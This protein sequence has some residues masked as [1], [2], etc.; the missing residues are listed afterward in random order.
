MNKNLDKLIPKLN[1]AVKFFQ[2]PKIYSQ[3]RIVSL[4]D[5]ITTISG[6]DGAMY[7]ELIQF[8]HGIKGIVL[9]LKE[10]E[11]GAV[12]FGNF[13]KLK[14]G[15]E[16]ITTGKTLAIPVNENLLG[17]VIN[18]LVQPL[19]SSLE[20]SSGKMMPLEKI[21]PGVITRQ[22]VNTP[23]HTGIKAIDSMIPIGRGQRELII[24]DKGTGKTAIAID[25]IINQKEE[26]V[27]CVYVAIGQ[28][29][30][31]IARIREELKRKGAMKYTIIVA[32]N[33]ADSASLQYIAPYAGA[34]IAEYFM[35][36]GKDVLVVYDD[37]SKHAWAYRQLS[38]LLRRPSGR[39]A[40]P[41]DIF[42]LHS[43]LLERACRLSP[44]YGGGSITALPIIEIQAN[45]VSAYIPTN[46]ISI[47][48]GQIYLE[49]D[50]FFA[51]VRPA[52]NVGLSVS[53]VG[54]VAQIKAMKKI[55]GTLRL[56]LAQY[57]ELAAFVQFSSELD[58][59]TKKKIDKGA[60]ITEIFK[61]A[62]HSP[63]AVEKQVVII[64]SAVNGFLEDIPLD[65]ITK[66]EGKL[67]E[68]IENFHNKLLKSIRKESRLLGEKEKQ[69]RKIL[70]SF[71]K[72]FKEEFN[73]I[74]EE[75]KEKNGK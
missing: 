65:L 13:K 61:Q 51:G 16:V 62:E 60:K 52:I 58:E 49:P 33:A 64:W 53:R 9:N 57:R 39:E 68:E 44:K 43:K 22:P 1:K 69:L 27:I 17:K 47:T 59:E 11:V 6:L 5:G 30:V 29:Q 42:Y 20:I 32:A 40:Y 8:P 73:L 36:K 70:E 71:V 50:L 7:N 67:L 66:F 72:K 21:A 38:L 35:E 24:G 74:E 12:I 10:D 18:P 14:E 63:L 23:L 45:D 2:E 46:V 56:E 3:G 26:N 25:T 28:R 41:G 55:A 75:S 15:D 19:D 48:D 37:L 54:G 4:G 31:R 34:A